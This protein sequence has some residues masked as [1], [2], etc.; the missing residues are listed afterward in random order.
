[1]NDDIKIYACTHVNFEIPK[2]KM[3]V[4]IST[5]P[6]LIMPEA[7]KAYEGDN[8][9]YKS[10]G[11]SEL[12]ALYWVWKNAH[13]TEYTGLCH[14]HRFLNVKSER[15]K[16]I[17]DEK[18]LITTE[19]ALI[20]DIKTQYSQCHNINDLNQIQKIIDN[21]YTSFK[22]SFLEAE[23]KRFL[24]I[25]NLFIMKSDDM[26]QY[27]N[28]LFDILFEFDKEN[29]LNSSE[30]FINRV[31]N[32]TDKS[33]SNG[34]SNINYQSRIDGFLAERIWTW[35]IANFFPDPYIVDIASYPTN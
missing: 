22:I 25:G 16:Q 14:Y 13:L 26:I 11:Y 35:Y 17:V 33:Y 27:C 18:K 28:V 9:G 20:N 21:K 5:N 29:N 19:V 10:Q 15:I 1:M 34:N 6:D 4:P 12:A 31:K 23:N 7:I 30:D 3:F 24:N 2:N 8:I 32:C